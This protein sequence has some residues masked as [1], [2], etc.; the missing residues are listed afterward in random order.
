[1]AE[2]GKNHPRH[3]SDAPVGVSVLHSAI[4]ADSLRTLEEAVG[5][6]REEGRLNENV[7]D[8]VPLQLA[9]EKIRFRSCTP[10]L[11]RKC[12]ESWYRFCA[13]D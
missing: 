1:M 4:L 6:L 5:N 10:Q 13:A 12:K 7:F 11:V 3:D 8:P 2:A 9:D